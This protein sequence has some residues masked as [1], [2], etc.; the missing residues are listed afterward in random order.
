MRTVALT[1]LALLAACSGGGGGGGG[2]TQNVA[3]TW[4]AFMGYWS[5]GSLTGALRVHIFA[6]NTDPSR[7][8]VEV[9]WGFAATEEGHSGTATVDGGGV[10][11]C[12]TDDG[13]FRFDAMAV[14]EGGAKVLRINGEYLS[15]ARMGYPPIQNLPLGFVA[16]GLTI[17]KEWTW[18]DLV[19]QV[20]ADVAT[21]R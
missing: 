17:A 18:P 5:D 6:Q 19:I 15:G 21:D 13:A 3:A 2:G 8:A 11:R 9:G 4:P 7:F 14:T 20:R 16:A 12:T 1:I 10:L